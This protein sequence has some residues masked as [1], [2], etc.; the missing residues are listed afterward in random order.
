[1]SDSELGLVVKAAGRF[2]PGGP[3]TCRDAEL[4]CVVSGSGKVGSLGEQGEAACGQ[5]GHSVGLGCGIG[6]NEAV[7]EGQ[8]ELESAVT[9]MLGKIK[10]RRR[11]RQR[12]GWFDGITDSM[13][14]GLGGFR[15]LVMDRAQQRAAAG[16]A[17]PRRALPRVRGGGR[18]LLR[19]VR[20][21]YR[22]EEQPS[23]GPALL[24][25]LPPQVS[26]LPAGPRGS[27]GP[28]HT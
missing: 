23:A 19:P 2:S 1:M 16:A 26:A 9:L 13:D 4:T 21:V 12:M 17:C 8:P 10:G 27:L 14:M 24:P 15:E 6:L 5:P 18:A 7:G 22:R 25:H 20:R 11:G 3:R 28:N